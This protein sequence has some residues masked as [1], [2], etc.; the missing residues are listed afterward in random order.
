MAPRQ[1]KIKDVF[2]SFEV[3]GP[4]VVTNAIIS[5]SFYVLKFLSNHH[6]IFVN[7]LI[8]TDY[9]CRKWFSQR[10]RLQADSLK[11]SDKP[12]GIGQ[13]LLCSAFQKM[14]SFKGRLSS[15]AKGTKQSLALIPNSS[16]KDYKKY[17]ESS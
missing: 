4:A 2:D 16:L 17:L 10:A 13:K 3:D 15:M 8:F 1:V 14:R 9:L 11:G 6:D 7:S 12:W 5:C